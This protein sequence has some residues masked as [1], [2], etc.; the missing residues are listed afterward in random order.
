MAQRIRIPGDNQRRK[1]K[2][3][4]IIERDGL[5]CWICGTSTVLAELSDNPNGSK[6]TSLDHVIPSSKGGSHD[7]DNLRIACRDC[8]YK[9]GNEN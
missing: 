9:R 1:K 8:N 3:D 2:R 7:D 6:V 5:A 4:R